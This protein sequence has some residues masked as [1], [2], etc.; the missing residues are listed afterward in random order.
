MKTKTATIERYHIWG[1]RGNY[2][3]RVMYRGRV[4]QFWESGYCVRLD[5]PANDSDW[6]QVARSNAKRAGFTAVR[7]VGDFSHSAKPSGGQL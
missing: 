3:A 1:T 4:V 6:A 5:F 2:Q 7:F